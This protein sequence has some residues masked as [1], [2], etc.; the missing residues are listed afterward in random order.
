MAFPFPKTD[1]ASHVER[2][3]AWRWLSLAFLLFLV[4]VVLHVDVVHLEGDHTSYLVLAPYPTLGFVHGGG[5]EG[6]YR[7]THPG[8]PLPWW[9]V[10]RYLVL[11][12]LTDG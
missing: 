6:H 7:R 10:G 3:A 1:S 2:R 5:E 9:L 12:E 4:L 8:A 11:A